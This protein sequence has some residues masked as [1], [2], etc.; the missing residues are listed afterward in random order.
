M[1][2]LVT[3]GA[4]F[5]GS[6]LCDCLLELKNEVICIDNLNDYYSPEQKEKNI[7]H[8]LN[9]KNFEF[10][11]RDIEDKE[12]LAK[13]FQENKFDV[14]VHLA[15]R[16]GVRPSLENPEIYFNTNVRGTLNILELCRENKIK[17]I[18]AS[19]SSVYGNN[20]IPF[21]EDDA[22]EEQL[23]PYGTTKKMGERLCEMYSKL[24]DMN[25]I[26]LRF[27]TV[28]G[29]RGRPDMAP[30]IFTKNIVEGKK[31]NVFGDGT[32]KRDY[33]FI[34]DIVDGIISAI[35]KDLKF[36]IINLGDSSP[37]TLKDFIG[38]I[39]KITGKKAIIEHLPEQK[40]DM[41]ATYAKIDKA[42]DLLDYKPKVSIEEGMKKFVGWYKN[43]KTK[44]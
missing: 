4:G 32:S 11:E 27:F 18:F 42:K 33:T 20:K 22:T 43:E 38:L 21:S 14:V 2:I 37:I 26:C 36:E 30:Y 23:S 39:E 16:A 31:I 13:I 25:I 9:N 41:K 6:N 17:M 44:K 15:A 5:I 35:N 3:G 10:C 12:A 34:S 1:K 19:S 7:K 8:N 40:G 29:P 24:Y 28:Y